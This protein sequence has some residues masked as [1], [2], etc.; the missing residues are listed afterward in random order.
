MLLNQITRDEWEVIILIS[1]FLL[2]MLTFLFCIFILNL[3]VV[4]DKILV[5]SIF[6]EFVSLFLELLEILDVS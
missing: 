1:L 2:S 4:V 5:D 3:G 6:A